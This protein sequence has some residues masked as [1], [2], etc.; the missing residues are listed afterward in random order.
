MKRCL[1]L[2]TLLLCACQSLPVAKAPRA[3][4]AKDVE[5]TLPSLGWV[6]AASVRQ[7]Q[8]VAWHGKDRWQLVGELQLAPG[9]VGLVALSGFGNFLFQVGYDGRQLTEKRSPLVP[10]S[11]KPGQLLSDLLLALMPKAALAKSLEG[12]GLEL[13]EK[14][15]VRTLSM[16]GKLLIRIH[17]NP[18][19]FRFEQLA[20]GYGFEVTY[21]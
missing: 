5:W 20:L 18:Q 19:G 4:L 11:A 17:Y 7:Q 12:T 8:V 9:Q 2:L 16:K 15:G 14:Q 21:G 1:L 3:V 13:E 6:Q 10:A